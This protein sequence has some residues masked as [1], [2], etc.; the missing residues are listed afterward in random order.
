MNLSAGY[1]NTTMP[2]AWGSSTSTNQRSTDY[3]QR[4]MT[5]QDHGQQ[6]SMSMSIGPPAHYVRE[7]SSSNINLPDTNKLQAQ[8][9]RASDEMAS[10]SSQRLSSR[11]SPAASRRSIS[12]MN[13]GDGR[14]VPLLSRPSSR[15]GSQGSIMKARRDSYQ[16]QS[17]SPIRGHNTSAQQPRSL[18]SQQSGDGSKVSQV[19]VAASSSNRSS[20]SGIHQTSVGYKTPKYSQSDSAEQYPAATINPNNT[21]QKRSQAVAGGTK[22][23]TPAAAAAAAASA[24]SDQLKAPTRIQGRGSIC[25][26]LQ[27]TGGASQPPNA[28]GECAPTGYYSGSGSRRNSSEQQTPPQLQRKGS[29]AMMTLRKLK[30]TMS[31][32]KGSDQGDGQAGSGGQRS[33]RSSNSSASSN[34][35][36]ADES[37]GS[38]LGVTRR[39]LAHTSKYSFSLTLLLLM[40]IG[41]RLQLT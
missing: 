15:L 10:C 2:I 7:R 32:N 6:T 19:E 17:A 5:Q 11:L 3:Q 4:L 26:A 40:A 1:Q 23:S 39:V 28:V 41:N 29:F 20:L 25:S 21:P 34:G 24:G 12:V 18:Q 14:G 13:V 36:Y 37:I 31:L 30:R 8:Q 33:R 22:V 35:S 38:D 16:M 27:A 9:R